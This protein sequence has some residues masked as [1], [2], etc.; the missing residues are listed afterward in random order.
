LDSNIDDTYRTYKQSLFS[1]IALVENNRVLIANCFLYQYL[2]KKNMFEN[3]KKIQ[4]ITDEDWKNKL[5]L[6][7]YEVYRNKGTEIPFLGKYYYSKDKGIYNC[8]CCG[9]ELFK[10][11]T[12]F[13]S[14][15]GWPSFYEPINQG[16]V[17]YHSD[18]SFGMKRVEITCKKCGS[19]LGHVFDDGPLPKNKRYCINSVSLTLA[20]ENDD[21]NKT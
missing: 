16:N 9:N 15:T 10:S 12:K 8:A 13:D 2:L 5:T 14:G 6:E 17:E 3:D 18:N 7:Q 21:K 19:H 4:G 1:L 11:D 20:K